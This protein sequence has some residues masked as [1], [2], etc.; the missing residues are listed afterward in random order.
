MCPRSTAR[1]PHG[2]HCRLAYLL[3]AVPIRSRAPAVTAATR[4]ARRSCRRRH[5]GAP[6]A[7]AALEAYASGFSTPPRL[8]VPEPCTSRARRA[9]RGGSRRA[10]AGQRVPR[11]ASATA[12][13]DHRR[14]RRRAWGAR[15]I[16]RCSAT[17]ARSSTRRT[18]PAACSPGAIPAFRFPVASARAE[19][20]AILSTHAQ[21]ASIALSHPEQRRRCARCSPRNSTRSSSRSAHRMPAEHA[22]RRPAAA[23]ARGRRDGRAQ[24]RHAP[25]ERDESSSS[26]TAI[27]RSMPRASRSGARAARR[28]GALPRVH[29]GAR[30]P[31]ERFGAPP[32]FSPPR[33]RTA[34]CCTAGGRAAGISPTSRARSRGVEIVAPNGRS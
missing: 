34:W 28:R 2:D 10:D 11:P 33:C 14:R 24:A 8:A 3:R 6:V 4:R 15:T 21:L 19:C 32:S 20:A 30:A 7:I 1:A 12:R 22:L 13:R 9:V 17:R 23:S 16:S 27:S 5:F 18:S 29:A 31:V 25:L 26:A